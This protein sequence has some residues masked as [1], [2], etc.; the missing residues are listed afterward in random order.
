M[1]NKQRGSSLIEFIFLGIPVIFITLSIIEA[2]LAMWQF[3][4]LAYT[5]DTATRYAVV[6]GRGCTQNGNACSITV[7]KVATV[8][9]SQAPA[10]ETSK[11]SVTLYTHSTTTTCAPI[12]TCLSDAT[13][14]PSAIDNG[15]NLDIKIVA[16]YPIL[17]PFPMFWPGTAGTPGS[18]FT[19]SATSRQ[20]I[21]F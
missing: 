2:S 18:A 15:L 6:H 16:T 9:S 10:L 19:L 4:S 13:Q 7:G 12:T 5:V 11:L 20:R 21:L 3:H 8:L 17:N 14:F 1:D